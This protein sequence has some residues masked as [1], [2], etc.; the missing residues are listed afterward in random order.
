MIADARAAKGAGGMFVM[1]ARGGCG[2]LLLLV[3]LALAPLAGCEERSD[4]LVGLASERE[5]MEVLVA[6]EEAGV[7]GAELVAQ[8][9]ARQTSWVVSVPAEF[10]S[11][12]RKALVERNLPREPKAGLAGMA[13]SSGI[14][15]T[16]T[17]ER[18][19]LMA[20]MASDLE[21]TL[22]SITG[23]VQAR[24]NVVLPVADPLG[25]PQARS[26]RASA[27][28]LVKYD[29]RRMALATSVRRPLAPIAGGGGGDAPPAPPVQTEADWAELVRGMVVK[30]LAGFDREADVLVTFTPTSV[31][32]LV[33]G[34]A[35][36]H[37]QPAQ[38]ARVSR[39]FVVL[40]VTVG[41][42]ALLGVAYAGWDLWRRRTGKTAWFAGG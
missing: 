13:N 20:A 35:G 5:A 7:G 1:Q 27:S 4:R 6:L 10:L 37:V 14:I 3:V 23:V 40:F 12:A 18:A 16:P 24:V 9:D 2:V 39:T 34:A 29:P 21:R 15:P 41:V 22:E 38:V 36:E 8:R 30:S 32:G 33:A 11:P 42:I 17:D 19:R 28:V 31:A 26:G 25:D